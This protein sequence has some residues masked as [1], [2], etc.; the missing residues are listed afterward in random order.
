MKISD[1]VLLNYLKSSKKRKITMNVEQ[2]RELLLPKQSQYPH[3]GNFKKNVL[4]PLI[5]EI[6]DC[7]DRLVTFEETKK[8]TK[9]IEVMLG[10]KKKP[11]P[12]PKPQTRTI[13]KQLLK[14]SIDVLESEDFNYYIEVMGEFVEG[15][16]LAV[17][18]MDF[19]EKAHEQAE[20]FIG[21]YETESGSMET[22]ENIT[23]QL[24]ESVVAREDLVSDYDDVLSNIANLNEEKDLL[25]KKMR[26]LYD[27][28]S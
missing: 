22:M 17:E 13:V 24:Y 18:Q 16:A 26:G 2:L 10:I 6:N 11:K 8:G 15:I 12:Q 19:L 5:N 25:I 14:S 3:Y 4:K 27:Q 7:T 1:N 9:V 20:N 28:L 21:D 23:E